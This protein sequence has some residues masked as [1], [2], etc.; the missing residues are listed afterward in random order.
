MLKVWLKVINEDTELLCYRNS[1]L[2]KT[3]STN[4]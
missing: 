3:L 4:G 2:T 1:P